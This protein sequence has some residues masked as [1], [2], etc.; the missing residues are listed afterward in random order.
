MLYIVN[1]LS[2]FHNSIVYVLK[3]HITYFTQD[4]TNNRY[5]AIICSGR[6]AG[7]VVT[8]LD[9]FG[10]IAFQSFMFACKPICPDLFS[11]FGGIS[12]TY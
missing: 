3:M 11:C 4:Q 7:W 5:L 8:V 2:I 9:N 10:I 6:L 1:L 12:V